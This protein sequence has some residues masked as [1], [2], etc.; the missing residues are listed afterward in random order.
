MANVYAGYSQTTLYRISILNNNL[1]YITW[2]HIITVSRIYILYICYVDVDSSLSCIII[3]YWR[4]Y[5]QEHNNRNGSPCF[6]CKIHPIF[7]TF[8]KR[9]NHS[10]NAYKNSHILRI[11]ELISRFLNK[12]RITF[13]ATFTSA[14]NLL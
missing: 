10:Y 1:V 9:L 7:M 8:R 5:T 3:P 2:V 4:F 6:I 13:T 12:L 11:E 14:F